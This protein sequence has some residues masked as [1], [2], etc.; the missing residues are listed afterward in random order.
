MISRWFWS[1]TS[2]HCQGHCFCL[3]PLSL[4]LIHTILLVPPRPPC[5]PQNDFLLC[6]HHRTMDDFL[7]D[8]CCRLQSSLR[9]DWVSGPIVLRVC[10]DPDSVDEKDLD[11]ASILPPTNKR[12][13][14]INPCKAN[15]LDGAF[16]IPRRVTADP[17]TTPTKALLRYFV[18]A[19]V[20]TGVKIVT[21][22]KVP[23]CEGLE[24]RL[25]RCERNCR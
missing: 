10:Q 16:Y 21:S 25:Y 20:S 13:H 23:T 1:S 6:F 2:L 19:T 8:Q 9:H 7:W 12:Q 22:T 3:P 15:Y 18:Q 17:N 14:R 24:G 4:L 11:L 5:C